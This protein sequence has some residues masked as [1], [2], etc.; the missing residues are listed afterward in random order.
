[1]P[2]PMTAED[3]AANIGRNIRQRRQDLGL[4][5]EGLADASGVSSTML[6]E[7]ERGRKNPTVKLAYQIALALGCSLT[8]LLEDR[9]GNQVSIIR[10]DQ[11]RTL[12][13]PGSGVVRRG[14]RS[15]LV[16]RELE[17][18]WYELPPGQSSGELRPNLPGVVEHLIVTRG[19]IEVVLGGTAHRLGLG[20]SIVYGP[21]S[22][23]EYRNPSGEPSEI[24]VLIDTSKRRP[25]SAR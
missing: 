10:A 13:D 3:P 25:S 22:T 11:R 12:V 20:D 24:L 15:E 14:L 21:Q 7:V 1:M 4:S 9:P 19:W 18:A 5:L 6:S 2:S 8:D 23:T 16:D 17:L